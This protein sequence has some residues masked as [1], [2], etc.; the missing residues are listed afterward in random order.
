MDRSVFR[1]V[2]LGSQPQVSN[3]ALMRMFF[4]RVKD[5][6]PGLPYNRLGTPLSD[7]KATLVE[8]DESNEHDAEIGEAFFYA[9]DEDED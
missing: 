1:A 8:L 6:D 7:L 3:T 9:V 4:S 5:D 2:E